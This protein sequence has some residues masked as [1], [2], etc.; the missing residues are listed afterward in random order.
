MHFKF[1]FKGG[2]IIV[3]LLLAF[4]AEYQYTPTHSYYLYPLVSNKDRKK[5]PQLLWIKSFMSWEVK[6][7][8]V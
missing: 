3:D 6:N 2:I 8:D 7:G 5:K 4:Y 1:W